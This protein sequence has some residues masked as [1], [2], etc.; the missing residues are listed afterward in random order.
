MSLYK[1][2]RLNYKGI[3]Y[4]IYDSNKIGDLEFYTL[5]SD[6]FILKKGNEILFLYFGEEDQS[7]FWDLKEKVEGKD[8][9]FTETSIEILR[10]SFNPEWAKVIFKQPDFEMILSG[11]VVEEWELEVL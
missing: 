5:S 2:A 9:Y 3:P 6:S 1:A 11:E 4:S 7:K 8:S 10:N